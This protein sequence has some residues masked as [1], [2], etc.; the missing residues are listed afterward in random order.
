MSG[1][2]LGGIGGLIWI[3]PA[4]HFSHWPQSGLWF[5]YSVTGFALAVICGSF[6]FRRMIP[7]WVMP[8]L[9]L[10]AAFLATWGTLAFSHFNDLPFLDPRGTYG[11]LELMKI[12][13]GPTMVVLTVCCV[14]A[15]IL[16]RK[17]KDQSMIGS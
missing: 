9:L 11:G 10:G 13:A 1:P 17:G 7:L 5:A 12:V 14:Y 8:C 6:L 16:R 2:A 3:I 4:V 15:F